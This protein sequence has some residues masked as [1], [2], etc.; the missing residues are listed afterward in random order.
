[1]DNQPDAPDAPESPNYHSA[2]PQADRD[3][4][5]YNDAF[6]E[7]VNGWFP[8]SDD[9]RFN[10]GETSSSRILV[11]PWDTPV[12]AEEAA[13][14][15]KDLSPTATATTKYLRQWQLPSRLQSRRERR[16]SRRYW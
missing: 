3:F 13:E 1:M 5:S 7:A 10:F 6:Q 14:R 16:S 2:Q 12:S 11:E 4:A 9:F 15:L 8:L